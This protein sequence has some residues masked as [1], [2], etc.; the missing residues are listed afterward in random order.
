MTKE[1]ESKNITEHFKEKYKDETL[2]DR[3]SRWVLGTI[4][5]QYDV[6]YIIASGALNEEN[7]SKVNFNKLPKKKQDHLLNICTNA[8]KPF[9]K[10]LLIYTCYLFGAYYENCKR[11]NV[12]FLF[13][14]PFLTKQLKNFFGMVNK[15]YKNPDKDSN[16]WMPAWDNLFGKEDLNLN[17]KF[18]LSHLPPLE[19]KH[20]DSI[21][22]WFLDNRKTNQAIQVVFDTARNYFHLEDDEN[23]PFKKITSANDMAGTIEFASDGDKKRYKNSTLSKDHILR[24]TYYKLAVNNLTEVNDCYLN[25]KP[26]ARVWIVQ[27]LISKIIRNGPDLKYSEQEYENII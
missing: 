6:A 26:G 19:K 23:S 17:K 13:T 22:N 25:T 9:K 4:K 20:F 15:F 18:F 16:L 3:T 2:E 7:S 24:S 12:E 21:V 5:F 10:Y 27:D 14:A 1:I 11:N 8:Y